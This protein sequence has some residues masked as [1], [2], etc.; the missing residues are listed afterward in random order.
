MIHNCVPKKPKMTVIVWEFISGNYH[1][2]YAAI[3]SDRFK[4]YYDV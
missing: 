4:H 1:M 2:L 3:G